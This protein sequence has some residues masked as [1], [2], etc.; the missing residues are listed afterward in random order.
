MAWHSF[1]QRTVVSTHEANRRSA[2]RHL[3]ER[4]VQ[5]VLIGGTPM[6]HGRTQGNIAPVDR[7]AMQYAETDRPDRAQ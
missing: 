6:L 2:R 7:T 5:I 4:Q 3:S 1:Y